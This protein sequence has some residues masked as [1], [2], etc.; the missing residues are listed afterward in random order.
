LE[1]LLDSNST[2]QISPLHD[3]CRSLPIEKHEELEAGSKCKESLKP[4]S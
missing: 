4:E 2:K 3:T 1:N